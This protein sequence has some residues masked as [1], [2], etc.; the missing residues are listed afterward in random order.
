M[1]SSPYLKDALVGYGEHQRFDIEQSEPSI[2]V[3]HI[4]RA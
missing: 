3:V 4:M 2:G 1:V